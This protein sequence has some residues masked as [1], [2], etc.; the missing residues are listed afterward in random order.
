MLG[1]HTNGRPSRCSRAAGSSFANWHSTRRSIAIC[2]SVESKMF[3]HAQDDKSGSTRVGVSSA[4]SP[5]TRAISR[6]MDSGAVSRAYGTVLPSTSKVSLVCS[7]SSQGRW[8][9]PS[10]PG[11]HAHVR[12]R[13]SSRVTG[14]TGF[15]R[16]A[17]GEL[18]PTAHLS[19][20]PQVCPC[21]R[22]HRSLS[23]A[24]RNVKRGTSRAAQSARRSA[25]RGALSQSPRLGVRIA[26]NQ[27][28]PRP[29]KSCPHSLTS[30]LAAKYAD[31]STSSQP[32]GGG[33]GTKSPRYANV[34]RH[35][36]RTTGPR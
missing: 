3:E 7:H 12:S 16:S 21:R 9:A 11:S 8:S 30:P 34:A 14:R 27:S 5:S 17:S 1:T 33:C 22:A 24:R 4:M 25:S 15:T 20:S 31:S 36:W 28:R 10:V 29:V 35:A 6:G 26:G 19:R 13:D 2:C 23:T 32:G 18:R